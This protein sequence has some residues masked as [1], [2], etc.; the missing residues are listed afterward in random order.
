MKTIFKFRFLMMVLIL[1]SFTAC[2]KDEAPPVKLS[3]SEMAQRLYSHKD[4]IDFA[5]SYAKNFKHL[6]DYYQSPSLLSNRESFVQALK[7]AGDDY[8]LIEVAHSKYG[9]DVEEVLFRNNKMNNDI[10]QLYNLQPTLLDYSEVEFWSIIK[11]SVLLLKQS[12][13]ANTIHS[14]SNDLTAKA[15]APDEIWDCLVRAVGLGA[16]GMLGI[17]GLHALAQK[18]GIQQ[19]VVKFAA[20]M[21]RNLGYIGLAITVFDF[22]SCM[23]RESMD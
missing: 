17:A 22:S 16:G 12:T 21:A 7:L 23:Y 18:K 4:F 13:S 2:K 20:V 8:H 15:I 11:Q 19:V 10:L 5:G 3:T 14:Y 9:L 6:A 1:A